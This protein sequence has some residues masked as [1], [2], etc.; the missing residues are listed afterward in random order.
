MLDTFR[1]RAETWSLNKRFLI[2]GGLVIL[3]SMTLV[4]SWITSRIA[5]NAVA[6]AGSATALFMDSFITPLAQEL[7]TADVLSIGPIRALD[8]L[9][10]SPSLQGRVVSIRIWKPGAILA[11][12][13]DETGLGRKGEPR[14]DMLRA[15]DGTVAA[16]LVDSIHDGPAR[17]PAGQ[18]LLEVYSPIRANWTGKIIA[19]AEVYEAATRL[20]A[21][22]RRTIM[23]GWIAVLAVTAAIGASLFGI[24]ANGSRTIERQ[25]AA[26]QEKVEQGQSMLA[27]IDRLRQ[28]SMR[29]SGKVSDILEARMRQVSADLHDG[30]AQLLG[31]VALRLDSLGKLDDAQARRAEIA[32]MEGALAEALQEIRHV[33]RGLSLP[34]LQAVQLND[35]PDQIISLHERRT[36][37]VVEK[38][39]AVASRP[40][41]HA[42]KTCLYR[43]IQEGLNN[44]HRH[45]PGAAVRVTCRLA[46]DRLEARIANGAARDL[47]PAPARESTGLGLTGL[48]ERIESLGGQFGFELAGQG[49]ALLTMD[50][51]LSGEAFHA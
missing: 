7:D 27:E 45:A 16:T 42:V 21:G 15:F 41:P 12:S 17:I 51:D 10:A 49:A 34:D 1:R 33:C 37:V 2:I 46:G 4:G 32:V 28:R 29:A 31:L 40:V 47:P 38:D 30:P 3:L 35:I 24:V 25:R 9:I 19:V 43:F 39:I 14:E 11:Y 48:K 36:G 44:A 26:L 5:G 13:S 18:P 22:I 8:E 20:Q 23:E 6:G 50:L